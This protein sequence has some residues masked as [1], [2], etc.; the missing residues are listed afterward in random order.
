MVIR[1]SSNLATPPSSL[2]ISTRITPKICKPGV[3]IGRVRVGADIVVYIHQS[4][5][6]RD[7]HDLDVD[8]GMAN[9]F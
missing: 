1:S 4:I 3:K 6:I 9:I 2:T 5:E 8:A 7:A